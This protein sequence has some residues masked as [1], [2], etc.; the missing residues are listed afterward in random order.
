MASKKEPEVKV[1]L[2]FNGKSVNVA[3]VAKAAKDSWS[4][5]HKG[6]VNDFNLYLKS[7]EVTE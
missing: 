6:D 4:K 5:N 3:D 7:E 1:I 2:E